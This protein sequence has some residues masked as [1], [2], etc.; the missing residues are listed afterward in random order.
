MKFG[1]RYTAY[2]KFNGAADNYNGFGRNASDHNEWF[3]YPWLLY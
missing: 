2:T 1:L 3:A